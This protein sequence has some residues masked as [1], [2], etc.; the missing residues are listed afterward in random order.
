[1]SSKM[2]EDEDQCSNQSCELI[3]SNFT[4]SKCS[5][6]SLHRFIHSAY[7]LQ[8]DYTTNTDSHLSSYKL[9]KYK[10]Q[11]AKPQYKNI[12]TEN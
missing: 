10:A 8:R 7:K 5:I 2:R 4:I 6:D 11:P 9:E 12:A 1:M 3:G